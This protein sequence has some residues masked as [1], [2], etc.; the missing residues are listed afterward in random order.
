M[1][2]KSTPK[3]Y[4]VVKS[5]QGWKAELENSNWS[6]FR[7]PVKK[8][9]IKKVIELAQKEKQCQVIIHKADGTIEEERLFGLLSKEQVKTE[10]L[11]VKEE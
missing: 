3:I 11:R 2:R 9:V 1:P 5:L 4:H 8:E 10:P 6:V 7:H